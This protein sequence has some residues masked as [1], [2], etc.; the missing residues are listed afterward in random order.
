MAKRRTPRPLRDRLAAL[1]PQLAAAAQ[2][3]YDAW[4]QDDEGLDEECGEGGICDLVADGI[5]DVL[6]KHGI[7]FTEGG[8]EGDDHAWL[9]A[10]DD[11]D[12]FGVDIAP[13]VYETGGGY[14]WKKRKGVKIGPEDVVVF[15]LKRSDLDV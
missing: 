14:S 5:G 13:G 8:H 9:I 12:A 2:R 15:K 3:E 4:Q 6:G 7:D 1:R 10:Y 11:R